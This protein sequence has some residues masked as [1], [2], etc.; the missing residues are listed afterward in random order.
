MSA[1]LLEARAAILNNPFWEELNLNKVM[2]DKISNFAEMTRTMKN[3]GIINI[4]FALDEGETPEVQ[5]EHSVFF[6]LFPIAECCRTY[7]E[8]HEE[9]PWHKFRMY[10]DG[11][12]Y[13]TLADE[14]ELAEL[15]G[16]PC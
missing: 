1:N 11:V 6:K 4:S 14:Q 2:L 5:L 15:D 8:H 7:T 10:Q 9:R 16:K 12:I 13:I 3:L